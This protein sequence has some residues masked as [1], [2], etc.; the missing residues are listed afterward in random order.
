MD[1]VSFV[2]PIDTLKVSESPFAKIVK[3]K[4]VAYLGGV[5]NQRKRNS[6]WRDIRLRKAV[7]HAINYE[8]LLRYAAKGNAYNL[9][10]IIPPGAFGYNPNVR[11]YAYDTQKARKLLEEAGYPEGF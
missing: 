4:D 11:P 7:C 9:G 1:I 3:S 8:E 2:R 10:G 5:F 6:K